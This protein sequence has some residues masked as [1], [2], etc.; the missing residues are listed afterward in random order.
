MV[1]VI[2]FVEDFDNVWEIINGFCKFFGVIVFFDEFVNGM[3]GVFMMFMFWIEGCRV[4]IFIFI[5]NKVDKLGLNIFEWFG[6]LFNVGWDVFNVFV[7][8][9]NECV[10]IWY[11]WV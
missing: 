10:S 2:C 7:E 11:M 6:Y 8:G 3:V 5:M 9:F 4:I 1:I